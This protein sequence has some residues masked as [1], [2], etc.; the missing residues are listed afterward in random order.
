MDVHQL[1]NDILIKIF[2]TLVAWKVKLQLETMLTETKPPPPMDVPPL[3]NDSLRSS[4]SVR[5]KAMEACSYCL[6]APQDSLTTPCGHAFCA[7][8]VEAQAVAAEPGSTVRCPNCRTDFTTLVATRFPQQFWTEQPREAD[9]GEGAEW[10]EQQDHL[11]E[12][13]ALGE[14]HLAE[15]EAVG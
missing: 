11:A 7:A 1:P 2:F 9:D 15:L 4:R 12:L 3:P 5:S 14:L 10:T 13:E 6:G 8:C